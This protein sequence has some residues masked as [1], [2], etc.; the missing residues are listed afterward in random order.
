MT[1]GPIPGHDSA[2]PGAWAG[3]SPSALPRH[4][5]RG[6]GPAAPALPPTRKPAKGTATERG[7]WRLQFVAA[8]PQM[9]TGIGWRRRGAS[10][11]EGCRRRDDSGGRRQALECPALWIEGKGYRRRRSPSL[12]RWWCKEP[13]AGK[14]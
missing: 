7:P 14:T 3:F 6:G 9:F 4:V 8:G 10:G 12:G 2:W 11:S 13:A 1:D 5:D